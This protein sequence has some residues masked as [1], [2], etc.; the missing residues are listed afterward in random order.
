M[1]IRIPITEKLSSFFGFV[2]TAMVNG[3]QTVRK[4]FKGK[5]DALDFAMLSL[6]SEI[7]DGDNE[8]GGKGSLWNCAPEIYRMLGEHGVYEYADFSIRIDIIGTF[9]DEYLVPPV[10]SGPNKAEE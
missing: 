7:H 8:N 9:P 5:S 6:Y 4:E 3:V 10:E 2:V 1:K